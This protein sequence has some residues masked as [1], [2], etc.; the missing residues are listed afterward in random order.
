MQS[1]LGLIV[2]MIGT[3]ELNSSQRISVWMFL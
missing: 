1:S 3:S 2:N